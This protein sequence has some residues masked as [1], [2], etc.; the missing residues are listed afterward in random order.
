MRRPLI[1]SAA[2]VLIAAGTPP[3]IAADKITRETVVIDQDKRPYYLFIP[4][5]IGADPAPLLLLFHGSS[6]DGRSLVE[7]WRE[8]ASKE[9]IILAGPDATDRSAWEVPQD[10]PAFIYFLVEAV[11]A[12]HAIDLRRLYLF[13][14]S[15]GAGFGVVMALMESE[16]FAAA[17]VH[18][19]GLQ[20]TGRQQLLNAARKIPIAFFQGTQ[21][22][23]VPVDVA[24]EAHKT[25]SEAGF[26]VSLTELPG[27]D[28]NYYRDAASI[29][30]QVWDFLKDAVLDDDP[31]YQVYSYQKRR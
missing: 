10:G 13:G 1:L 29:N 25:L 2:I 19:G 24:R 7:P 21:D 4:E 22:P 26:P 3:A 23:I 5:S 9:H 18:A 8:I 16:Y 31:H 15:A 11:K 6:R 17:A 30:R 12:R 28:H 20:R 14:H 27:H